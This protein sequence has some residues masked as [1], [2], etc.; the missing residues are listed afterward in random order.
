MLDVPSGGG[1]L[2]LVATIEI[3]VSGQAIAFDRTARDVVFGV[4]RSKREVVGFKLPP[5]ETR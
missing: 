5:L 3:P 2:T 4:N 1:V